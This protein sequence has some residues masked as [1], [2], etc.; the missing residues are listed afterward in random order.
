M[1]LL[2]DLVNIHRLG[3]LD[4]LLLAISF[5][6]QS[7]IEADRAHDHNCKG[8]GKF[9]FHSYHGF[10]PYPRYAGFEDTRLSDLH[11]GQVGDAGTRSLPQRQEQFGGFLNLWGLV[12]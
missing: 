1:E 7:Q 12:L 11:D 5:N 2:Q 4:C 8:G 6:L 9:F 10:G 3:E